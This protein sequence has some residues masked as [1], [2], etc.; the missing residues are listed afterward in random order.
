MPPASTGSNTDGSNLED[1]ELTSSPSSQTNGEVQES[2]SMSKGTPKSEVELTTA[3]NPL[4]SVSDDDNGASNGVD[5]EEVDVDLLGAPREDRPGRRAQRER[6]EGHVTEDTGW[7]KRLQVYLE[8]TLF[9]PTVP[10]AAQLFRKE[11]VCIILCYV[12]VGSF[13]GISSG[14]MNVY[15]LELGA[16]EAQQTTIKVL[17]SVPA[18]FKIAYGFISDAYP[19]F[20][21]RRKMYMA[22]GWGV[23]T[24]SMGLLT[25]VRTPSIPF[26]SLM[27]LL[28]GFGFWFADVMAD[29]LVA[30][31]AK[32]EPEASQGTLQS[33]CYLFRFFFL[34][35]G[36]V[37]STFAYESLG[38]R[39]IFGV[40]ALCPVCVIALPWSWLKEE[41]YA[42]V[43]PVR[44]QCKEIWRTVSNRSV[45]QP[46]AFVYLF[47]V[48]QIGNAAW[49]QY[50]YTV[51]KFSTAQL[52]SILVAVE[53]LLFAGV[54]CY[55]QFLRGWSW[56]SVYVLCIGLNAIVS[57]LQVMLIYGA[58]RSLGIPDFA[59][60][61][62]DEGMLEFIA[63]VQFLPLTIMMV[64][65]C[66]R[67]SEGVSYAMFTTMNNVALILSSNL[68]T[69]L[70]AI[71]DVS[72]EALAAGKLSGFVKLTVLTTCL[73][74]SGAFFLPL[75]PQYR[76]DLHALSD[77]RSDLG[78]AVFLGVVGVSLLWAL[79][80]G[81]LNILAPGWAGESRR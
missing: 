38:P 25:S 34:M 14:V 57:A 66:P 50:L 64:H 41:R 20:G 65:L 40:L 58:N 16:T 11:N 56:R 51:L 55:K 71:W 21:Y 76:K 81:F 32:L 19:I 37:V 59:F 67:G 52:N 8:R 48:V 22:G 78:G 72:E 75:L 73:Q 26:L 79:V 18:S 77:K 12:L 27:Y 7:K 35:L 42:P 17:R 23:C 70:L 62:G 43:A 9:D 36:V 54:L 13:Q 2:V 60:A 29:A 45:F 46:M 10:R 47:N 15:P 28:F 44:A 74:T 68:G 49:T 3:R 63:G 53:V 39:P 24:L 1:I 61:L 5:G 6:P 31:K 30:E 4:F 80:S 69:L 33:T